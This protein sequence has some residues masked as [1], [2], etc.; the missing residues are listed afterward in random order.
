VTDESALPYLDSDRLLAECLQIVDRYFSELRRSTSH[1][2]PD[3]KAIVSR[4]RQQEF[5]IYFFSSGQSI[6]ALATPR[7]CAYAI[8]EHYSGSGAR[9]VLWGQLPEDEFFEL[10]LCLKNCGVALICCHTRHALLRFPS[11]A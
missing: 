6:C 8:L 11:S 9:V 4:T 2:F 10:V 3:T 1:P 7:A 5:G